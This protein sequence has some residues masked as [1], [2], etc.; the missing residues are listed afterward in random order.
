MSDPKTAL[1]HKLRRKPDSP[2]LLAQLA[3]LYAEEGDQASLANLLEGWARRQPDGQRAAEAAVQAAEVVATELQDPP[4]AVNLASLALSRTRPSES[5][6]ARLEAVY[7]RL[8]D[9]PRLQSLLERQ[10]VESRKARGRG[11]H[12][13]PLCFRVGEVLEYLRD[14]AAQALRWYREAFR[15]DD[16]YLPALQAAR[17]LYEAAGERK[18]ATKLLVMEA[19]AEPER[20]RRVA[21]WVEVAERCERLLGETAAAIEA[22][23]HALAIAPE[24]LE[25]QLA[26]AALLWR[27]AADGSVPAEQAGRRAVSERLAE[28]VLAQLDGEAALALA[29]QLLQTRPAF[30]AALECFWRHRNVSGVRAR[31]ES[32]LR[33]ARR[34][35][36]ASAHPRLDALALE[37]GREAHAR[38]DWAQARAWLEPALKRQD[39]EAATLLQEVY[40]A[41]GDSEQEFGCLRLRIK[42][43]TSAAAVP[44]SAEVLLDRF[45]TLAE[46]LGY[47]AEAEQAAAA[48]LAFAPAH[49]L[50]LRL[51][52]AR[53]E[54]EGDQGAVAHLRVR[55]ALAETDP[56]RRRH[57]LE[58]V[59]EDET[60]L[61]EGTLVQVD[62]A[63]LSLDIH[64]VESFRRTWKRALKQQALETLSQLFARA[65]AA[66]MRA[67][68]L[69]QALCQAV[70]A[71]ADQPAAHALLEGMLAPML[72]RA[73]ED[74]PLLESALRLDVARRDFKAALARMDLLEPR[75]APVESQ[76]LRVQRMRLLLDELRDLE[77]ARTLAAALLQ[78]DPY[79]DEALEV[80]V[81]AD[82]RREQPGATAELLNAL[83]QTELEAGRAA[84]LRLRAL[85]AALQS[86][87]HWELA[88][89]LWQALGEG[90]D[91]ASA[92][93]LLKRQAPDAEA[94]ARL[95][96][97]AAD[98]PSLRAELAE[99]LSLP[100]SERLKR[101]LALP[102]PG[103]EVQQQVYELATEIEDWETARAAAAAL[104][105]Q[106]DG[107]DARIDHR[108]LDAAIRLDRLGDVAGARA[109]AEEVARD[110]V[111]SEGQ[112]LATF[113]VIRRAAEQAGDDAALRR[114][115]Q[116]QLEVIEAPELRR[117][118][119][120]AQVEAETRLALP[121]AQR[122]PALEALQ[123]LI[124]E[125]MPVLQ[126]LDGLYA[127]LGRRRER[128]PLL[129]RRFEVAAGQE[130]IE[131]AQELAA[132]LRAAGEREAAW[133]VLW[134]EASPQTPGVLEALVEL[135][136]SLRRREAL[137]TRFEGWAAALSEAARLPPADLT[138][139]DTALEHSQPPL[140]Q[141]ETLWRHVVALSPGDPA[142]CLRAWLALYE[143]GFEDA[144]TERV[145]AL[146]DRLRDLD[147]LRRWLE[148]QGLDAKMQREALA[149][150]AVR[151]GQAE[152]ALALW[153]E[154]ALAEPLDVEARQQAETLARRQGR[155][156]ALVGFYEAWV[157]APGEDAARL[158]RAVH[159][160]H[161]LAGTEAAA[162][163]WALLI[164]F[165]LCSPEPSQREG[166]AQIR[167]HLRRLA[168][169]TAARAKQL[170]VAF[171]D[172]LEAFAF[173]SEGSLGEQAALQL[174]RWTEE[175]ASSAE[176]LAWLL[177]FVR[178]RGAAQSVLEWASEL[179]TEET[180][181]GYVACVYALVDD[182][183]EAA[184]AVR[185]LQHLYAWQRRREDLEG[186]RESAERWLTLRID[187]FEARHA[188]VAVLERQGAHAEAVATLRAGLPQRLGPE[189]ALRLRVE[190]ARRLSPSSEERR[191]LLEYVLAEAPEHAEA[192]ELYRARVA[193]PPVAQEALAAALTDTSFVWLPDDELPEQDDPTDRFDTT[194][195]EA[196]PPE[197]DEAGT[198]PDIRLPP[199]G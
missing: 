99:A 95:D 138:L 98:L 109:L 91:R 18:A 31:F 42:Q 186:A 46:S 32:Y 29:E 3:A 83:L 62:E 183:V 125:D 71:L 145:E 49:A 179:A 181:D 34:V 143:L 190:L 76:R 55:A 24:R 74:V 134:G 195:I 73:P 25:V 148:R 68:V 171:R 15:L 156:E 111:L 187:D 161:A 127:E 41:L 78:E 51:H 89:A 157:A 92:A 128:V 72:D 52:A 87:A 185:M 164:R 189:S 130:R 96:A 81:H 17:R 104:S 4:R 168:G 178:L 107:T 194:A 106:A 103:P 65:F 66:E 117:D 47:Q 119:L 85:Q 129:R 153:L 162:R 26:F 40:A 79:D 110:A 13:A 54:R 144:T 77:G 140:V 159:A 8:G 35:P 158:S 137:A 88:F 174:A 82:S 6:Y 5:L 188:L 28:N 45:V 124:P 70:F 61:A 197:A 177:R 75:V 38:G 184:E 44:E 1:I 112:A 123:A 57:L 116:R 27:P 10:L 146:L 154:A 80:L 60:L 120:K 21:C 193:L 108:L 90:A 122:V 86:T 135:S 102:A 198:R 63:M 142:R 165:W 113:D 150:R 97:A 56:S 173:A 101:L 199:E 132:I 167:L 2:K 12:L 33:A 160:A 166:L 36:E 14:D 175:V 59:L 9:A 7:R 23:E 19:H 151:W 172:A 176:A 163:A 114:A 192:Q 48:L 64:A 196:L 50:A 43:L 105:K 94:L 30:L 170:E 69:E 16:H 20:G 182:A 147:A 67:D 126:Q 180:A 191:G 141:A 100:A 58:R 84:A 93:A 22:Y 37:L 115:L 131:R 155:P 152:Q 139:A 121:A 169:A 118:Y 136:A 149:R 11:P 53:L 133:D 39:L